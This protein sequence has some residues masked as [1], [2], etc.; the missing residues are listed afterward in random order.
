MA[1]QPHPLAILSLDETNQAR[2]VIL[3]AHPGASIYFRN[4]YLL[5]PP[6][7]ELLKFLDAEHSGQLSSST[8]RPARLAEVKYDAIERGSKVPV[9]QEASVDINA[10]KVVNHELI[11]TE[12]HASLTLYAISP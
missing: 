9:Y 7:A 12:F 1:P 10:K 5:E 8:P 3:E 2:D 11:S 4:I 6:K